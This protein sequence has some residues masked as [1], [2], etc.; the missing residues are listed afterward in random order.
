VA[1][2]ASGNRQKW[3]IAYEMNRHVVRVLLMEMCVAEN[4]NAK[5]AKTKRK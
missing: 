4:A 2:I 3:L 5:A 1:K